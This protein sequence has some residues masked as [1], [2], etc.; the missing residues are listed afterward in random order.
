[1]WLWVSNVPSHLLPFEYDFVD[2][3]NKFLKANSFSIPLL[4][5]VWPNLPIKKF[6]FIYVSGPYIF[7]APGN[8]RSCP[9]SPYTCRRCLAASIEDNE[10]TGNAAPVGLALILSG[11]SCYE[12]MTGTRISMMFFLSR[13]LSLSLLCLSFLYMAVSLEFYFWQGFH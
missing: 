9:H 10:A 11:V 12:N 3:D 8:S 6:N 1:M 7:Q 5:L 2:S 4:I 13:D